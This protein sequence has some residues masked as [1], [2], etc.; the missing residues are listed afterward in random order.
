MRIRLILAICA[1]LAGLSVLSATALAQQKTEKQCADEWRANRAANQAAKITEKDFVAK[2]RAGTLAAQP[3]P[4]A[5]APQPAP[6]SAVK[7]APPPAAAPSPKTAT[8]PKAPP[9]TT[10]IAAGEFSTEA[11]AKAGCRGDLVV[12]ANLGSKIY[13]FSGNKDY[14]NTKEG[15]YM[16]EKTALAQGIRAAK[17][18]KHP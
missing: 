5:P 13:H 15:A 11:Q 1:A 8:N 7:S 14:G 2:C 9:T 10:G 12:W 18:E 3:A 16:C 17:N 6:K 4:A